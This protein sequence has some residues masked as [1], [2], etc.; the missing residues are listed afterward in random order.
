MKDLFGF[1]WHITNKCNLRCLH[2]YQ[3]D[4]AGD[5][6]LNLVDLKSIVD[7]IVIT[8]AKWGKRGDIAI[9]GG[10]PHPER[11]AFP[12]VYISFLF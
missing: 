9:T 11:G 4:Y 1:Q 5:K 12:F 6:E 10:E 7:E 8:L 2:C 3:E